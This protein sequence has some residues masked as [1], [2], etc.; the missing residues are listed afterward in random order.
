MQLT[1]VEHQNFARESQGILS[2]DDIVG[3]M[4][5]LL[6]RPDAGDIIPRSGGL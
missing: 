6:E 3:L 1:F 5:Q 4:L 2:E